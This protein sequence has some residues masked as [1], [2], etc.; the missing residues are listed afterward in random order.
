MNERMRASH[1]DAFTNQYPDVDVITTMVGIPC[2]FA[3]CKVIKDCQA[4][5]GPALLMIGNAETRGLTK[6]IAN[7]TISALI[8]IRFGAQFNDALPPSS[9]EDTFCVRYEIVTKDNLDEYKA[10][11]GLGM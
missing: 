9:M 7:G 1:F 8:T 3:N 11:I 6:L 2:D 10:V 4:N 5:R